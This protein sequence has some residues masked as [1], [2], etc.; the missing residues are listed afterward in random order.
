MSADSRCSASASRKHQ[1]LCCCV[2]KDTSTTIAST[3]RFTTF[4]TVWPS[5]TTST[6]STNVGGGQGDP[7]IYTIWGDH[8]TLLKPGTFVAWNFS[9]GS[10]AWQLVACYS[11]ARF[12]TQGLLLLDRSHRTM[13]LTAEDCAWRDARHGGR[14]V[15]ESE[16]LSHG[17]S[18]LEVTQVGKETEDFLSMESMIWL[19]MQSENGFRKLA[20]KTKTDDNFQAP[21]TWVG[22][23]GSEA[24]AAYLNSKMQATAASLISTTCSEAEEQEAEKICGKHLQKD[25]WVLLQWPQIDG[26][27]HP[28]GPPSSANSTG[29]DKTLFF[30]AVG[31]EFRDTM[32]K[33]ALHLHATGV[34][35]IFFAHYRHLVEHL[36]RWWSI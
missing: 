31:P 3:S 27:L 12:T 2:P 21:G 28:D 22:L 35:D 33:N 14:P 19:K 32:R 30:A 17:A 9:K 5:S 20:V 10:V 24:A 18:A 11:G 23:G 16:F 15:R 1:R 7:H 36:K 8:Y 13:E 34:V 25:A 29:C 26:S 6:T 4:T